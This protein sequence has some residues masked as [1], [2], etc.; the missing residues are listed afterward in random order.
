MDAASWGFVGTI[1][2]AVVGAGASI[3]TT[4]FTSRNARRLQAD[5]DSLER[6]ERFR[7]FQRETL[8]ETQDAIHACM[9]SMAVLFHEQFVLFRRTGEWYP[10][11]VSMSADEENTH[12]HAL[13]SKLIER[14]ADDEL[15]SD[16]RFAVVQI[17]APSIATTHK[18]A[19]ALFI[20]ANGAGMTA[21]ASIGKT[22]REFY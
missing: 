15:R 11:A 5:A 22:L 13:L 2:G 6:L 4:I 14:V 18:E 21:I 17:N 19:E 20:S 1:A 10:L 3:G 8:L 16:L 12:N 7:V 9:R